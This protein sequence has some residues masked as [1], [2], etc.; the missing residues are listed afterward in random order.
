MQAI[1]LIKQYQKMGRDEKK[2]EDW[3]YNEINVNKSH[4][5]GWIVDAVV[6]YD[7]RFPASS[8]GVALKKEEKQK[9][10]VNP[11][12]NMGVTSLSG[13][14]PVYGGLLA[15][16]GITTVGDMIR[17]YRRLGEYGFDSWLQYGIGMRN[18]HRRRAIDSM[19]MYL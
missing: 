15:G 1:E 19:K 12:A 13:I 3:L 9:I 18:P 17:E 5:R 11:Y 6:D 10:F 2:F 14:G 4:H 16:N 7:S 8:T